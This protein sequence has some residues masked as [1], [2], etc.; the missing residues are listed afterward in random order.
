MRFLKTN[1][2]TRV[3]VGPFIDVT[4]AAT[5]K[6]ADWITTEYNNQHIPSSFLTLGA[7]QAVG[8]VIRVGSMLTMFRHRIE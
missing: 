3:T 6:T 4:D 8:T 2:A 7:E 5:P 1:T